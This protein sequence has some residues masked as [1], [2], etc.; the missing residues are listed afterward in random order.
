MGRDDGE[1]MLAFELYGQRGSLLEPPHVEVDGI[2]YLHRPPGEDGVAQLAPLV[3]AGGGKGHM[4]AHPVCECSQWIAA[5]EKSQNFLK[6]DDVSIE[7]IQNGEG[8]FGLHTFAA[9]KAGPPMHIITGDAKLLARMLMPVRGL[10]V[11]G[12]V[13]DPVRQFLTQLAMWV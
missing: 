12:K 1:R 4:V 10:I 5:V 9:A 7:F 13:R 2:S 8:Q 6:R 11:R 3:N